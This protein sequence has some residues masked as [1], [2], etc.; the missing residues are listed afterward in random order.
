MSDLNRM[1]ALP[2]KP[3]HVVA[4]VEPEV[5]SDEVGGVVVDEGV[6][7]VASE[8][9]NET[10]PSDH[11]ESTPADS[12][13]VADS[14]HAE[15]SSATTAA[16]P[17]VTPSPAA[18]AKTSASS[19]PTAATTSN[20]SLSTPSKPAP[21][22]TAAAAPPPA[23]KKGLFGMLSHMTKGRPKAGRSASKRG[24]MEPKGGAAENSKENVEDQ[25][26]AT[27]ST[28]EI[29]RK[30]T[31]APPTE[32]APVEVHVQEPTPV[33]ATAPESTE[34]TPADVI[35]PRPPVPNA[36]PRPVP[37]LPTDAR[38][39]IAE[40]LKSSEDLSNSPVHTPTHNGVD[41]TAPAPPPRPVPRPAPRTDS[42]T[43]P[44]STLSQ[45]EEALA[46]ST[47]GEHANEDGS[48]VR[49]VVPPKPP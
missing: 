2:P 30:S 24:E 44:L 3:H 8:E 46:A 6:A 7:A 45:S 48:A 18:A 22:T 41:V 47:D 37:A 13:T 14:T 10:A 26:E 29:K 4:T 16:P 19:L 39:S 11:V 31:E 15:E 42:D 34:A 1:L 23:E 38:K 5:S 32:A 43:R 40:S 9:A 35:P 12:A 49:P 33:A 27:T 20:P 17:P 36:R 25:H 21:T 28:D